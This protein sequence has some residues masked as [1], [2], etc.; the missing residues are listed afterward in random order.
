MEKNNQAANPEYV[1]KLRWFA[2]LVYEITQDREFVQSVSTDPHLIMMQTDSALI[3]YVSQ[4]YVA[5][6][7]IGVGN[8]NLI[9]ND[10]DVEVKVNKLEQ[11]N[12]IKFIQL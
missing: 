4:L 10:S 9:F 8:Y 6:Q 5:S 12:I 7:A 1:E 2:S 11:L 3:G